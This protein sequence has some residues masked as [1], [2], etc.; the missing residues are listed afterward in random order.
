MY[1]PAENALQIPE[2]VALLYMPVTL[3][4]DMII[5]QRV[6]QLTRIAAQQLQRKLAHFT[7]SMLVDREEFDPPMD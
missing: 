2:S 6:T 4:H 1:L 3:H 5:A 7:T